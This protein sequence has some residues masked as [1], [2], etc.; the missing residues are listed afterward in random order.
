M[1]QFLTPA[2]LALLALAIP[3]LLLWML[4][5]RRR[6]VTVASTLLWSRLVRDREANAPWQRL[7]RNLLLWLQL[8]TLI[9]LALALARPFR[10]V[11]A[12]A[13]G[14]VVVVLDASASM[15]ATDV[16]PSRF[17]VAQRA[18]TD[19]VSGLGGDGLM[20]VIAAGA[21][22]QVLAAA[23]NDRAALRTAIDTARPEAGTADWEAA[24]ALA[25]GATSGAAE[26][27][28]VVIS[29][30]NLSADVPPVPG[31]VR[32]IPIGDPT[33]TPN[34]ALTALA[35]RGGELFLSVAHTGPAGG[36]AAVP[37]LAVYVDGTLHESR[38]LQIEPGETL[39]LT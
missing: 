37:L 31:E 39:P 32:Y 7:R 16:A 9:A 20:T 21:Q 38:W 11:P 33:G 3:I 36:P 2:A 5:L 25:A 19:L 29:D 27:T 10:T 26:S 17:A 14:A 35:L 30:G 4:K 13:G 24:L 1:I 23:T 28:I 12:V 34:L 22:P 15:Q 6:D 8:A 18:A